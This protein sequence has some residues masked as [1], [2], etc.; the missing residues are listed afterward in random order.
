MMFF[1]FGV[2]GHA[3][4]FH[5]YLQPC[6]SVCLPNLEVSIVFWFALLVSLAHTVMHMCT[7]IKLHG[8]RCIVCCYANMFYLVR[9]EWVPRLWECISQCIVF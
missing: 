9:E 4:F 3:F 5:M 2:L 8:Y 6:S 1:V 7:L